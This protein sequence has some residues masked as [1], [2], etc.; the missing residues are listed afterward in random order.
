TGIS[1]FTVTINYVD[2]SSEIYD[3][4]GESY[5]IQDAVILQLPQSCL[6]GSSGALKP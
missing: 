6:L 3:N 2:G 5:P 4:N 1:S